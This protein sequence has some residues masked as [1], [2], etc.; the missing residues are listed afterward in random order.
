MNSKPRIR[1]GAL[2]F[3]IVSCLAP[4]FCFTIQ[5]FGQYELPCA[6]PGQLVA[7][8]RDSAPTGELKVRSYRLEQLADKTFCLSVKLDHRFKGNLLIWINDNPRMA[9]EGRGEVIGSFRLDWLEQDA[10]ISLSRWSTPFDVTSLEEKLKLPESIARLRAALPSPVVKV[11]MR[12]LIQNVNG[13]PVP[14][15]EIDIEHSGGFDATPYNNTWVIQVGSAEFGAYVKENH[16]HLAS[17]ITEA[18]F[19]K[20]KDGD[21]IRV[22]WGYGGIRNGSAGKSL[23]K[24]DKTMLQ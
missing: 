11:S 8:S 21:T 22:N 2:I 15:I 24:L 20:L 3:R 1:P 7:Q 16:N 10:T 23:A 12:R 4:L 6:T 18:D 9:Y 5:A 19:A 13:T 14:F 17:T